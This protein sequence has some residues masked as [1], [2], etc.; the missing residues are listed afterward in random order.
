[1]FLVDLDLTTVNRTIRTTSAH[2]GKRTLDKPDSFKA[3]RQKT[4]KQADK[5]AEGGLQDPVNPGNQEASQEAPNGN[6]TTKR[7]GLQDNASN[8]SDENE[9]QDQSLQLLDLHTGNPIVSYQGNI[10]SCSWTDMIGTTM[11]FSDHRDTPLYDPELV[12]DELDM[13]GTSRIKLVGH[14]AKTTPIKQPVQGDE[15]GSST[16]IDV[17]SGVS[18]GGIRSSNAKRNADL[19]K[20]ANFLEQLMN[21]KKNRGEEDNVRIVMNSKIAAVEAAGKLH[22]N[23]QRRGEE[24]EELNKKVV[25]GDAEA[26]RKLEQIYLGQDAED[27]DDDVQ[28]V[29]PHRTTTERPK[30]RVGRRVR[31]ID[32]NEDGDVFD[33]E[34]QPRNY[35][36]EMISSQLQS[37][38]HNSASD[39]GLNEINND[40]G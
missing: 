14:L 7:D 8:V 23:T 2:R 1:M 12:T 37:L 32:P 31:I 19:R 35:E 24:I 22:L 34:D 17:D 33:V 21:V 25:R 27:S 36:T 26:L 30:R 18:L 10:F 28:L 4:G 13:M 11:F 6:G 15:P 29:Q 9:S 40:N 39:T 3:K 20:Q 38:I 5:S 16:A